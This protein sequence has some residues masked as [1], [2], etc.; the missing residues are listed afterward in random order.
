MKKYFQDFSEQDPV[1][2]MLFIGE[3]LDQSAYEILSNTNF[4][5]TN[6]K[7]WKKWENL[8]NCA[9]TIFVARAGYLIVLSKDFDEAK[10]LGYID[11]ALQE[12]QLVV[13][14]I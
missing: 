12:Y 7:E 13:W 14:K 10:F 11:P 6:G 3:K 8:L 2:S 1:P 4:N 5:T 9:G